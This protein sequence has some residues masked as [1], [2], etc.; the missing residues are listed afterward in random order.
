MEKSC[1]LLALD[2][3]SLL[4]RAFYGIRPLSTRTGQ[5]TNGV[6]GFLLILFKLLEEERPDGLCVVF[7]R[8]EPTFRHREYPEYKAQRRPTPPELTAQLPPL[9]E[10][11]DALAVPRYE[12]AG[13]EGDDLL[14][15]IAARCAG[16]PW[17]PVIVSGDRDLLQLLTPEISVRLVA[18][19]SGRTES[20][21]YTPEQFRQEYGFEPPLLADEKGLQGD[22]SDHLPGVAGVGEKTARELIARFGP[23][24]ELYRA[25][26]GGELE[27]ALQRKLLAGRE[28]A[29]LTR[30]LATIRRDAPLTFDPESTRRR[31][32]RERELR[33]L[34]IQLEFTT[35]LDRFGLSTPEPEAAAPAAAEPEPR[36][37]PDAAAAT[38][39]LTACRATERVFLA[40]DPELRSYA[41]AVGG[42]VHRVEFGKF[43]EFDAA[44]FGP[45]VTKVGHD[46]KS[47]MTLLLN[48][49]LAPAGFGDDTALAAYLLD[50]ALGS[51]ALPRI[52]LGHL[53]QDLGAAPPPERQVRAV[54]ELHARLLPELRAQ[55]LEKLYTELELP[56]SPVLAEMEHRG[57]RIDRARLRE[58]GDRLETELTA[59]LDRACRL[60]GETFN[61]GSPKQLGELLF[62]KLGLKALRK[63]KT[64]YSTDIEVLQKLRHAH[65]VIPEIIRWR[66][67]AKLN[68]TYVE[69]LLA[70]VGPDDRVHTRFNMTAT[71]TGRLSSADPNLQNIPI[72]TELGSELRKMFVP[73]GPDRLLIDADYSQ[74]EL[75]LLAHIADDPALQQAFASGE[76]IH[77]FTASQVFH[78]PPDRIT[79]ELRRRAKAVNFGIVYGISAFSLAEN[80]GIP[81]AEAETYIREYLEHY[82]GVRTYMK[83]IVE[84]ARA[85]GCVTTL[86]GRRRYLPELKSSNFNLRSFGERAA[87]NTP[88][89]GTAADIIKLAM[90]RVAA[91]LRR[92]KLKAELLLQVHDELLLDAPAAEEEA[93]RQ[94]LREEME[95]VVT[96]KVPLRVEVSSGANWYE[97]K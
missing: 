76:D 8:R 66:Q 91:R 71:A 21:A 58:F 18:T 2:G 73:A 43:P 64:G 16:T 29:F 95:Q 26:D 75:R 33:E 30:R 25:V 44:F 93:V 4:S 24:E 72:R 3:N 74:I 62:E 13:Y 48:R 50:P 27:G 60:A 10:L 15:T 6:Y 55:G 67:L 97:A 89:Q 38:A 39:L 17:R 19:R 80:L 11:L 96:L 40:A 42:G 94:L 41:V 32:P 69:G 22:A 35:F 61:P 92:E 84:S 81:R 63:T 47:L 53:Q 49:G 54:A 52:A 31:A 36:P 1:K 85:R 68:S 23:L 20:T 45:G 57:I 79:P 83:E 86:F 78:L 34:L 56:L 70:V 28:A 82:A 77:T 12:L 90:I 5:P 9:K 7:D 51:Y 87:L 59:T 88:I 65:P 46:L 14:G 37:V